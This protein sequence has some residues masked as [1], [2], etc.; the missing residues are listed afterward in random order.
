MANTGGSLKP[1]PQLKQAFEALASVVS[2]P[3]GTVLFRRGE[4]PFGIF[5]V[6]RG[7]IRLSLDSESHCY[8][9]RIVGTDCVVGLPGTISG[10]PYSL[11]ADVV[12]DAELAFVSREAVVACL[13]K[14][15]RLCF[16]VMDM[17][18]EEISG[19]R[20]AF[21]VAESARRGKP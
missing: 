3:K 4:A 7:K 21:K 10:N 13:Q 19:I 18:S 16:E 9:T 5:L 8:P 1:S 11:T 2:K 20:A 17:L 14:D 6:C 12:Q 15:P